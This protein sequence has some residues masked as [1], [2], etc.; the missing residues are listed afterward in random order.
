[1]GAYTEMDLGV[2]FYKNTPENVI[3][4]LKFMLGDIDENTSKIKHPLFETYRWAYM[5]RM[6][7]CD[8]DGLNFKKFVYDNT[9]N[10]WYLTVRCNL[11]NYSNEIEKFLDWICPYLKTY[12]FLGYMRYEDAVDPTLIYN[13]NG[14]I[15]YKYVEK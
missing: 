12:G 14:E 13:D 1:M 6:S 9:D 10:C 11:K 3:S 7:S 8:F 4:T 5:L 15:V 2:C